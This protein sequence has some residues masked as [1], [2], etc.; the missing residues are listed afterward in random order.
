MTSGILK[1]INHRDKLFREQLVKNDAQLT[2]AYRKYRNKVTRIIE[3]AKGRDMFNSFET[4]INNPKKVWC[5][6]NTKFLHKKHCGNALPSEIIVDKDRIEDKETI[7]NKLNGHFVN[8]GHILASKLPETDISILHSM[9]PRN[10]NFINAWTKTE[11]QE[12]LDIINDDIST[13]KSPGYDNILALLIKWSSHIIAPV[14]VNI[15]N[16]FMNLGEYPNYLKTAKVTTLHK[17]GVIYQC[18]H[19]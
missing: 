9:Q 1:S 6:I 16:R 10:L 12:V 15:F 4:I 2:S 17:G 18:L 5:K 14:L 3:N 19:T 7:A 8:K 13:S 11:K